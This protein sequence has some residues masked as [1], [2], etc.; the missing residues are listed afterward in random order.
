ML[1][2]AGKRILNEANRLADGCRYTQIAGIEQGGVCG[3]VERCAAAARIACIPRFDVG[4]HIGKAPAI[5][6]AGK[7][8]VAACSANIRA[9]SDKQLG[10]RVGADHC[11]DI[12]PIEHST[13]RLQCKRPLARQQCCTNSGVRRNNAGVLGICRTHQIRRFQQ[14]RIKMFCRP[15]CRFCIIRRK[16]RLAQR[17]ACGAVKLAGIEVRQAIVARQ[18]LGDGALAAGSRAIDGDDERCRVG[19]AGRDSVASCR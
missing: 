15:C 4:Q 6:A 14:A 16:A 10:W 9:G 12:A 3:A 7:L 13:A 19:H 11:A 2:T 17:Q 5:A 8:G 1:A 18:R